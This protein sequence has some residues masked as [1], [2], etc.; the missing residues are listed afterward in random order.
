MSTRIL[1]VDDE[2][3]IR[4][5]LERFL[6]AE[7]YQ[8]TTAGDYN[9]AMAVLDQTDFDLTFVDIVLK[10]K[11]GID[12]LREIKTRNFQGQVVMITGVPTIDTASESVRLGAFDYL[13]KP[14]TQEA[15]LRVTRA[16]LRHKAL[17]DEKEK[18][19]SNLEAIFKSVKDAIITVDKALVVVEVNDAARDICGL[20]RSEVIGRPL[21]SLKA[22]CSNSCIKALERTV[23]NEHSVEIQHMECRCRHRPEQV[24]SLTTYPLINHRNRYTGGV[25]VIRDETRLAV[26]EREL[27]SRRQFHNIVGKSEK[28]QE[29]Y[30]LIEVLADVRTSVLITGESGTGKELV[31]EA[32]HDKGTMPD[33]PL[34][35][36]NCAAMSENLLE[37]ELFGHVKGAFT[38]AVADRIGRFQRADGG[39]ILL[40]EIGEM[41]PRTQLHLL[42]VL[43][44][45]EFERVG[46]STP[47]KVDVR[48]LAATNKNLMKEIAQGRF[49]QDL[50]YRLKVVQLDLPPLRDKREDIPIL[51]NHFLKRFNIKFAKKITAVSK[52]V[53]NIFMAYSWPGNVRELRH[54][55]EHASLLC[56]GRTIGVNHLPA[57]LKL[58][59]SGKNG[60]DYGRVL[61]QALEKTRWN[62][63]AA[64][65]L[66]GM[67]R[68]NLY[69]KLKKFK[70]IENDS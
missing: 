40:D 68:Q 48:V 2:E 15:L 37:S 47:I 17:V 8:V 43:Q 42:R 61:R 23:R 34:I 4:F 35:K 36:V 1:I 53:Q 5:T 22:N 64:A 6:L 45:M 46:D 58:F 41:T 49:R 69:R 9:G 24:V 3:N 29:I 31:A 10:G 57:E 59:S 55:M 44:S 25:I 39:T 30:M 51:T 16:A 70:V 19:Q 7:G 32:I 11:T 21:N 27:K 20:D 60:D 66:L 28:M 18:Y 14:V 50:Y 12:I 52:N 56:H 13:P 67:S 63:T 33:A 38:G 65:R 62:K 26:L 54:A